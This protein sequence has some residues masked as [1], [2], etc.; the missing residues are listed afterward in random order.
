MNKKTDLEEQYDKIYRYCYFKLHKREAA[1]DITQEA[2]LRYLE[3]YG[4][5]KQEWDLR[6]LYRIAHNLCVDEYRKPTL[7]SLSEKGTNGKDQIFGTASQGQIASG[8]ISQSMLNK[9]SAQDHAE[10]TIT[11]LWLRN[12]LVKLSEEEQEILLLRYANEVPNN[13]ISQ[14]LGISR[15]ALYRKMQQALRKLQKELGE[16]EMN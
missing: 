8:A 14:M 6:Y 15:F 1:E 9:I 10:Q 3:H 12:A 11:T 13:V 7:V 4:D 2:F 16:E 5:C